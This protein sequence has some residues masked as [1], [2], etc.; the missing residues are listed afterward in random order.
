MRRGLGCV[1]LAALALNTACST[2]ISSRICLSPDSPIA[3]SQDLQPLWS[4]SDLYVLGNQFDP[5]IDGIDSHVL[6]AMQ[7]KN[8]GLSSV[9]AFDTQSGNLLWQ[10]RTSLPLSMLV[11][12]SELYL[13]ENNA[14]TQ[15]DPESGKTLQTVTLAAV[16]PIYGMHFAEN[17]IFALTGSSRS[18]VYKVASGEA[19]LSKPYLPDV[20]F[21]IEGGKLYLSNADGYEAQDAATHELIW[22]YDIHEDVQM[23]PLFTKER[24]VIITKRGNIYAID[25]HTGALDWKITPQAISN[26]ASDGSRLYFLAA[27]GSLE[28]VDENDGHEVFKARVSSTPF[29]VSSPQGL[30]GGFDVWVDSD[31]QIIIASLGDR[32]QL[33]ALRTAAKP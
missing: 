4:K 28:A 17:Q 23:R 2:S 25:K 13:G 7:E 15:V 24:M 11:G 16:G 29:M 1:F 27:E 10:H 21:V 18:L 3:Q 33:V 22:K 6:V 8:D 19:E 32:C 20:P 9:A 5:M 14:I 26:V 30:V 31:N 12:D